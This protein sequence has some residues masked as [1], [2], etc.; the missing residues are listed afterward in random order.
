ME[1]DLVDEPRHQVLIDDA[2]AAADDDVLSP[3][4]ARAFSSAD[5]IPSVTKVNVVSE[6]VSGSRW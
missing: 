6:S 1:F 4:A 5:G 3:A 2:G